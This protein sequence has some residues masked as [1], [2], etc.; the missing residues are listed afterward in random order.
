MKLIKK[1]QVLIGV[2]KDSKLTKGTERYISQ[3]LLDSDYRQMNKRNPFLTTI[4]KK[5][6]NNMA[7]Q[8]SPILTAEQTPKPETELDDQKIREYG[9]QKVHKVSK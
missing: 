8:T 1:N 6:N 2:D 3:S 5:I 9:Y 7:V 4:K